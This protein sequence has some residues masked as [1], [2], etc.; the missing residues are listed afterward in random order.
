MSDEIELD[1]DAGDA[2]VKAIKPR[3]S[4]YEDYN[5]EPSEDEDEDDNRE[6][7]DGKQF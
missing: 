7:M 5:S 3:P 4:S 2:N 1:D 6:R